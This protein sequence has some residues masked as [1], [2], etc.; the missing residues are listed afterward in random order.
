MGDLEGASQVVLSRASFHLNPDLLQRN[1]ICWLLQFRLIFFFLLDNDPA[2]E[3]FFLVLSL[4]AFYWET[5][6][7]RERTCRLVWD[8]TLHTPAIINWIEMKSS[9]PF[10]KVYQLFFAWELIS[11]LSWKQFLILMFIFFLILLRF[12]VFWFFGFY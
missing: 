8:A 10:Q 11:I 9:I 6:A 4:Q 7:V 12:P 5:A 1:K 2:K 3:L